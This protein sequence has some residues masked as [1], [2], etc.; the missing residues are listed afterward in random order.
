M[1]VIVVKAK[2]IQMPTKETLKRCWEVNPDGAGF[3]VKHPKKDVHYEK[4][5][6]EFDDFYNAVKDFKK[7]DEVVMHFRIST[8]GGVNQ[9]MTHPFKISTEKA[10]MFKLKGD[11]TVLFHNGILRLTSSSDVKKDFPDESD[12]SVFV[13]KFAAPLIQNNGLNR[14]AIEGIN[15]L[16]GYSN[17][18]IIH[19]KKGIFSLG[20]FIEGNDGCWYSNAHYRSYYRYWDSVLD[21]KEVY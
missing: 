4:G 1:C 9:A 12:T 13:R 17:K 20:D 21:K 19:S 6:Q 2:G 16:I 7:S 18:M 5:F 10:D 15:F 14:L 8:Q 3:S 11:G